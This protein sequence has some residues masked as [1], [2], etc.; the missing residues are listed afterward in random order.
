MYVSN[1]VRIRGYFSKPEGVHEQKSFEKHCSTRLLRQLYQTVFAEILKVH[2]VNIQRHR[3]AEAL[4]MDC[5]VEVD[6]KR[7]TRSYRWNLSN[8]LL[9]SNG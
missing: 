8:L 4:L 6:Q 7:V 3:D 1:G 9:N 5:N 2:S